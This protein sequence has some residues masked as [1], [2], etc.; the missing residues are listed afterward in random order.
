MICSIETIAPRAFIHVLL[1]RTLW[2][3]SASMRTY[4]TSSVLD[5]SLIPKVVSCSTTPWAWTYPL[6]KLIKGYG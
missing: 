3:V 5:K 6:V 4:W 2:E 1:N